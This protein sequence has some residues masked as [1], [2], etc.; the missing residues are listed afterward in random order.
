M[1]WALLGLCVIVVG[2]FSISVFLMLQSSSQTL[3]NALLT[4][5]RVHQSDG[6]RIDQVLDRLMAMDFETF[7]GFQLAEEA[8]IGGQEFPEEPAEVALE[9]PGVTP[10]YG[11]A[12]LVA[13]AN[14]RRIL[15]ED[16]PGEEEPE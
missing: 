16:F 3:A 4:L 1:T 13:A 8:D 2:V 7:K 11:E 5:E 12:D 9:I 15:M 14:E 6:K 10:S